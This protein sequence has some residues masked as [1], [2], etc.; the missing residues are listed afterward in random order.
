MNYSYKFNNIYNIISLSQIT[1]NDQ[2]NFDVP[3]V[4]QL[5]VL[6]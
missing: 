1:I 3:T 6:L 4:I 5:F 2:I